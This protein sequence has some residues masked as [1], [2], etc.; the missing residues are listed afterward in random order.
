MLN[1][2]P[3]TKV[4]RKQRRKEG[5]VV[6]WIGANF[7]SETHPFVTLVRIGREHVESESISRDAEVVCGDCVFPLMQSKHDDQIETLTVSRVPPA[8]DY[9]QR[10]PGCVE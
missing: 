9:L 4:Q 2:N 5:R 3:T 1:C 8:E 7:Q 10:P 6:V